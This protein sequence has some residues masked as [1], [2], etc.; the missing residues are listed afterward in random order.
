MATGIARKRAEAACVM[1]T[2]KSS[3]VESRTRYGR[4]AWRRAVAHGE[5]PPV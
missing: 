5:P 2:E 4:D 3:I 1:R